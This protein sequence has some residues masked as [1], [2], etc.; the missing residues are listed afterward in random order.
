MTEGTAAINKYY[1]HT[2]A[3]GCGGGIVVRLGHKHDGV[4]IY[5]HGHNKS[6]KKNRG[7]KKP[8]RTKEHCRNLSMSTK[9]AWKRDD[10]RE[11]QIVAIK[12]AKANLTDKKKE[13]ISI[14]QSINRVK[15]I[16]EHGMN[17]GGYRCAKR[18]VFYSDKNQKEIKHD[19]GM[20]LLAYQI[21]EQL[22]KVKSYDGCKFS[23]DYTF[24]DGI[25]RYIPDIDIVY[26]DN[27]RE[28]IEIKPEY[29]LEDGC[30]QAKFRAAKE[31]CDR[32]DMRYS[33]WTEKEIEYIEGGECNYGRNRT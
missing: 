29:L 3:C 2:C 25:H 5:I 31:Y 19:S 20:E 24:K 22:S 10:V 23:I 11:K 15:Y 32:N 21:L 27:T 17:P 30:N 12:Q 33:V 28:I 26:T 1:E 14:K 16:Q 9:E 18:G 6:G 13:E 7:K 8:L 4:P